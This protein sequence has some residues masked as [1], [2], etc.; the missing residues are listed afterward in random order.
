VR[1]QT[2]PRTGEFVTRFGRRVPRPAAL[3]TPC[4]ECPKIPD[5]QPK[6]R[7]FAVE[8]DERLWLAW[9]F[10]EQNVATGLYQQCVATGRWPQD[11]AVDRLAPV[12]RNAERMREQYAR[13]VELRTITAVM[14]A[15]GFKKPAG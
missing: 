10:Y 15:A 12:F 4:D 5:G 11:D 3:P 1:W 7:A 14:V 8:P 2:D 9:E 13:S 6:S